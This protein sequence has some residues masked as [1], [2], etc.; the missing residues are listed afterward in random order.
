MIDAWWCLPTHIGKSIWYDRP[1][2]C[3]KCGAMFIRCKTIPT[4]W[5]FPPLKKM[6]KHVAGQYRKSNIDK[7]RNNLGLDE[8]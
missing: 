6:D 7:S 5:K 3:S 1:H 2:G 4:D 8:E